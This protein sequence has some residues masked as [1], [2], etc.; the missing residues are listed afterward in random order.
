MACSDDFIQYIVEQCADAGEISARKMM[1]DYCIYCDGVVFGI[2][3]DNILYVKQTD[4][5]REVLREIVLRRPYVGAKEHFVITDV[6][7]RDYLA[8]I[9]RTTMSNLP[10]LKIDKPAK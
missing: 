10:K 5:A 2:I 4:A 9:V 1:G 3:C 7:D 6:D 8:T